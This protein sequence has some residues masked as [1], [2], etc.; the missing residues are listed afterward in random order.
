MKRYSP[1]RFSQSL[2]VESFCLSSL[3]FGLQAVAPA[4][5]GINS[6]VN[7]VL[8]VVVDADKGGGLGD[9]GRQYVG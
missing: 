9:D 3:L 7:A 2:A 4:Q 8:F 6:M 1:L 5:H